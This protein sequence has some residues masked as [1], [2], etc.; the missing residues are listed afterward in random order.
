MQSLVL[1]IAYPFG[2]GDRESGRIA[3]LVRFSVNV[4]G[5]GRKSVWENGKAFLK[6]EFKPLN[7][8]FI[9]VTGK[10]IGRAHV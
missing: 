8:F 1:L 4:G 7:L 6:E 3:S 10:Q 9:I 5:D 2:R